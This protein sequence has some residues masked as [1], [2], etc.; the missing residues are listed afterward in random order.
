MVNPRSVQ[1][2]KV[3]VWDTVI[4]D[5]QNYVENGTSAIANLADTIGK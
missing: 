4:H 5:L 3:G 1:M 2:I